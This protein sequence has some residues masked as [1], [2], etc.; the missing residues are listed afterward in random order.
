MNWTMNNPLT[1]MNKNMPTLILTPLRCKTSL[2]VTN[3]MDIFH[4]WYNFSTGIW[5]C[6]KLPSSYWMILAWSGNVSSCRAI[7][8]HKAHT[9]NTI[10]IHN[11]LVVTQHK[12]VFTNKRGE[13]ESI[14]ILNSCLPSSKDMRT[15][16]FDLQ[17]RR[18]YN[19]IEYQPTHPLK[20]SLIKPIK[21]GWKIRLPVCV[22]HYSNK[23]PEPS[24]TS[25][26][27]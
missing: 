10:H 1:E 24:H 4:R 11:G 27:S 19:T 15:W 26:T 6:A 3:C 25:M 2:R 22:S 18:A 20:Y 9:F 14:Y 12:L 8:H 16:C 13:A 21:P 7:M 23:S 5:A 17:G